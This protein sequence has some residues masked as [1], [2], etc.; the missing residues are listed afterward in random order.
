MVPQSTPLPDPRNRPGG[1]P[2]WPA[3]VRD[4]LCTECEFAAKLILIQYYSGVPREKIEERMARV[5]V[6]LDLTSEEVCRGI[7]TLAAVSHID[8]RVQLLLYRYI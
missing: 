2:R 8:F 7:V 6:V 5:C 3:E 4:L 1:I